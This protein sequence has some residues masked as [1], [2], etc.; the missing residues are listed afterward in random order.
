MVSLFNSLKVQEIVDKDNS[1]RSTFIFQDLPL[2]SG[3][4]LG[5]LLRQ[6]LL[7]HLSGIAPL[8]V[9][10]SDKNGPVEMIF[11]VISGVGESGITA[12]LI[13]NLK[14]IIWVERKSVE[15]QQSA[16]QKKTPTGLFC[17]ELKLEN[18]TKKERIITAG[19][20]QVGPEAE[21]KNPELK[22]AVLSPGGELTIKLY[23]QK[24]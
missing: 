19:D 6:F 7:N 16:E 5:N 23:C 15:Q 17:C 22:L 21:I 11:S 12:E 3:T 13:L 10:I 4:V 14:E 1:S 2:G 9:E 20:F 24:N 8:A 18:K